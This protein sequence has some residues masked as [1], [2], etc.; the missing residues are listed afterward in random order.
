M[1]ICLTK[2]LGQLITQVPTALT[3]SDLHCLFLG[4]HL[5]TLSH[6]PS[7]PNAEEAACMGLRFCW[8]ERDGLQHDHC[9]AGQK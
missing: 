1:L 6:S 7:K 9:Q 2:R 4:S 5:K 3:G 8:L